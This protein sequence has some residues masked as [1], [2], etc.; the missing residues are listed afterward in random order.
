MSTKLRYVAAFVVLAVSIVS[1]GTQSTESSTTTTSTTEATSTTTTEA[2]TTTTAM[3]TTTT[4]ALTTTVAPTTTTTLPAF[5]PALELLEHGGEVWAVVLAGSSDI[6]DP[7][8]VEADAAAADA[9]YLTGPTDCDFGAP[10]A[11]GQPEG[12]YTVSV[13]FADEATARLALA[14]FQ[15]RAV[16]GVV[17]QVQTFCL[18]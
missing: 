18:D 9:G 1:C 14:A 3:A 7:A 13:Y 8:V 6:E 15:A 12:N 2:T 5:P 4:Q 10:E 16:T 11:L 17:A